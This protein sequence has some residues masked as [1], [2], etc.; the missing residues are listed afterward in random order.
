MIT[1]W[2]S[3]YVAAGIRVRQRI[4]DDRKRSRHIQLDDA[5]RTS[6]RLSSADSF[7]ACRYP[8]DNAA[9]RRA[10]YLSLKYGESVRKPQSRSRSLVSPERRSNLRISAR[11]RVSRR[12]INRCRCTEIL[13]SF[14][15]SHWREGAS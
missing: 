7:C 11:A 4:E 3:T 12:G 6:P 13:L 14:N 10:R 15:Y 8:S 9:V 2:H 5:R 1:P